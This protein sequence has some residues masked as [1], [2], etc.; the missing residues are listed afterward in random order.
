MKKFLYYAT[1]LGLTLYI[2]NSVFTE[3]HQTVFSTLYFMSGS[4]FSKLILLNDCLAV[5]LLFFD[6]ITFIFFGSL[7]NEEQT[8]ILEFLGFNL[9]ET[10]FA[11]T[12]FRSELNAF[13][14]LLFF[15]SVL[16]KIFHRLSKK[17]LYYL[18]NQTE[19]KRDSTNPKEKRSLLVN[20]I[21]LLS[22]LLSLLVLDS[23]VMYLL[24]YNL[25]FRGI[26]AQLLFLT[27]FAVLFLG[28]TYCLGRFFF[29]QF[30][31][32]S[33]PQ[34]LQDG[35]LNPQEE[36]ANME[37]DI[38][39]SS[40]L[41]YLEFVVQ[42]L[43]SFVYLIF[44]VLILLNYGFP[45]HMI[46]DFLN[47]IKLVTSRMYSLIKYKQ[48]CAELEGYDIPKPEELKSRQ[49][50][51]CPICLSYFFG[52]EEE[53]KQEIQENDEEKQRKLEK[54]KEICK[55]IRRLGCGHSFHKNC[56]LGSIQTNQ[57]CPMCR[58][59][60]SKI[61]AVITT[62]TNNARNEANNAQNVQNNA[63][64]EANGQNN[65][66]TYKSQDYFTPEE[67]A[68]LLSQQQ[69]IPN[70]KEE[71]EQDSEDEMME[72]LAELDFEKIEDEI[73]EKVKQQLQNEAIRQQFSISLLNSVKVPAIDSSTDYKKGFEDC[74]SSWIS[75]EEKLS[76]L[77]QSFLV[78]L[79]Q[80]KE[81]VKE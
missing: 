28:C 80:I 8:E 50:L 7:R 41:F 74:L 78:E 23:L 15:F 70:M 61:P 46:R 71:M 63:T 14:F 45:V 40:S 79:K 49:D 73:F 27:E 34:N 11:L 18:E 67:F 17:R 66:R 69:K 56:L 43:Q 75:H 25:M 47:T 16:L 55:S 19:L 77:H 13:Y 31:F 21:K 10:C 26:S 58:K 36:A 9:I 65:A 33:G 53:G 38:P 35:L 39:V 29:K 3:S 37:G 12:T 57:S 68:K 6:A 59:P 32:T 2:L 5:F 42:I 22:F 72:R 60:I 44:F 62:T 48:I 1:S 52:E 76:A 20:Q 64:N 54:E 30:F 24:L 81:K 51:K 4:S